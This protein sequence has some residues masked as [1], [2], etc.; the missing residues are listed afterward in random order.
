MKRLII[1]AFVMVLAI[2]LVACSSR[3]DA[4]SGSENTTTPSLSETSMPRTPDN[5]A[6]NS[7]ST[8]SS[9]SEIESS[10]PVSNAENNIEGVVTIPGDERYVFSSSEEIGTE[11]DFQD[12]G[13]LVADMENEVSHFFIT[14][15]DIEAERELSKGEVSTIIGIIQNA[16][17]GIYESLGN[18]PTGGIYFNMVAYDAHEMYLHIVFNG[19]WVICQMK[20]SNKVLVFNGESSG[21]DAIRDI[22]A[23]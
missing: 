8:S 13:Y 2:T 18:P 16:P 14:N 22:I 15:R 6:N 9:E 7:D 5:E 10:A 23:P 19:E 3:S 12:I 11:Q 21:L 1:L 4:R 17:H 20:G